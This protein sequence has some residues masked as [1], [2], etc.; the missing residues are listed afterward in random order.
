MFIRVFFPMLYML[1]RACL[2]PLRGVLDLLN[3]LVR[4]LFTKLEMKV[5]LFLKGRRPQLSIRK[6]KNICVIVLCIL[7]FFLMD[8][9]LGS[10]RSVVEETAVDEGISELD[11]RHL[12][13]RH[14]LQDGDFLKKRNYL[15]FDDT[16]HKIDKKKNHSLSDSHTDLRFASSL[17]VVIVVC[18]HPEH[19][20]L[21]QTIRA[22]WGNDVKHLGGAAIVF[23]VG[24]TTDGS[25]QELIRR[26][27]VIHGDLVQV[28]VV[29]DYRNLSRKVIKGMDWVVQN[30]P[31]TRYYMKCDDDIY[32][33]VPYL[34][35][36]LRR[37]VIGSKQ[38]L[39]ALSS[40]ARVIRDPRDEWSV[41]YTV[42]PADTFPPYVA[43]GGY[44]MSKLAL[45]L[46]L[47][48]LP[49]LRLIHLEDVFITGVLAQEAGLSHIGHEGFSFWLSSKANPCDIISCRR[50]VSVN[51][52]AKR[53]SKLY[54]EINKL[55]STSVDSCSNGT[56]I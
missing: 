53:I 36:E 7:C 54:R 24:T 13:F 37:G 32:L 5:C 46:L 44:V 39:G 38:I 45:Q 42:F 51:M 43:G 14:S 6:T 10:I 25:W 28:D 19:V 52:S 18:S 3:R 23:L 55:L 29:E 50:I 21:R 40:S 35:S 31:R 33:N 16:K 27:V 49:N 22:T 30:V 2:C 9:Q 1:K 56:S 48:V 8:S 11:D 20:Q 15:G 17:T 47:N 34:L 41:P 12:L 26:E 4:R